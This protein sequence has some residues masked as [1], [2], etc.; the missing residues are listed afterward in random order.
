MYQEGVAAPHVYAAAAPQCWRQNVRSIANLTGMTFRKLEQDASDRYTNLNVLSQ[1]TGDLEFVNLSASIKDGEMSIAPLPGPIALLQ[2]DFLVGAYHIVEGES[3]QF[4]ARR[5]GPRLCRRGSNKISQ[6]NL[7]GY[8]KH[9]DTKLP[10][11]QAGC[12][13]EGRWQ[14]CWQSANIIVS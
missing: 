7:T 11:Q 12:D 14:C 5:V 2:L 3:S 10:T 6:G 9:V 1:R 4:P 13:I 8:N